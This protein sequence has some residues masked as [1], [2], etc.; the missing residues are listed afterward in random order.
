MKQLHLFAQRWVFKAC[1]LSSSRFLVDLFNSPARNIQ[2]IHSGVL[3]LEFLSLIRYHCCRVLG[4][5]ALLI[6]LQTSLVELPYT[7]LGEVVGGWARVGSISHKNASINPGMEAWLKDSHQSW[8]NKSFTS[9]SSDIFPFPVC[10]NF[11]DIFAIYNGLIIPFSVH[12]LFTL[13]HLPRGSEK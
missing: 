3:K 6:S 7:I 10:C 8:L 9:Y 13:I 12:T 5:P 2:L 1:I 4:I 11:K